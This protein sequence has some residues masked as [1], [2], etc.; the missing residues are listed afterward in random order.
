MDED[1]FIAA[2][3]LELSLVGFITDQLRALGPCCFNLV[4]LVFSL[5]YSLPFEWNL[6]LL[7]HMFR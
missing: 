5:V 2:L 6:L 7:I 1:L 3:A 4:R